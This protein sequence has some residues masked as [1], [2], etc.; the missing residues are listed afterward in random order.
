[1]G[2]IS[3]YEKIIGNYEKV[4]GRRCTS[5]RP[6]ADALL[7]LLTILNV[8]M[9]QFSYFTLLLH[10]NLI[11]SI[12]LRLQNYVNGVLKY[13]FYWWLYN[14]VCNWASFSVQFLVFII[15]GKM[16]CIILNN[17]T[18]SPRL[19]FLRTIHAKT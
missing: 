12:T 18:N 7:W 15:I 10:T 19:E 2:L 4:R 6:H 17:L 16:C 11:F 14:F 13:H 1:M 3:D 5:P 8:L 9:L